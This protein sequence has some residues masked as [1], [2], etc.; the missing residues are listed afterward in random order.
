MTADFV[1]LANFLKTGT[2]QKKNKVFK[3]KLVSYNY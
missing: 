1:C 2:R 3:T